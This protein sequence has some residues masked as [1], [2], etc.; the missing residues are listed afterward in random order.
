MVVSGPSRDNV[1]CAKAFYVEEDAAIAERIVEDLGRVNIRFYEEGGE[2]MA[3]GVYTTLLAFVSEA[4]ANDPRLREEVEAANA[5]GKGVVAVFLGGTVPANLGNLLDR[6]EEFVYRPGGEE[7]LVRRLTT[8]HGLRACRKETLE[9]Y[10]GPLD[11]IFVSYAHKN[12]ADVLPVIRDLQDEGFRV[13][14]DAGIEVG[15][16]WDAYIMDHLKGAKAFICFQSPEFRA[17]IYCKQEIDCALQNLPGAVVVAC[18]NPNES[19]EEIP[20]ELRELQGVLRFDHDTDRDFF[21]KLISAGELEPCRDEYR[22]SEDGKVL[23]KYLGGSAVVRIPND[24]EEVGPRAVVTPNARRV[25]VPDG[26]TKIA[27]QAFIGCGLLEE[28]DL[29]DSV[30]EIGKEA[31][32]GCGSLREIA[33]PP[34]VTIISESCFAGCVSLQ[35]VSF[36]GE[37]VEDIMQRAFE[38]CTSLIE[39]KWPN[40]IKRLWQF[41]FANCSSLDLIVPASVD[42]IEGENVYNGCQS[43]SIDPAN[44]TYS[45]K[46]N[47][48]LSR[49][50]TTLYALFLCNKAT[51]FSI[52]DGVVSISSEPTPTPIGGFGRKMGVFSNRSCLVSIHFPESLRDIGAEA[53]AGCTSLSSV[54]FPKKLEHLGLGAFHGCTSLSSV[55]FPDSL[56]EIGSQAF[57]YC[58]ALTSI[59]LPDNLESLGYEAFGWC[60]S[61]QSVR[62]PDNLAS[63]GRR[64]GSRAFAGCTSLSAV[65]LPKKLKQLG[66]E[67]FR[68]CTSLSSID[69]PSG[70]GSIGRMAFYRCTSLATIHLP[71]SV[72]SLGEG[73]F[74]SCTSLSSVRLSNRLKTLEQGVFLGCSSL[75]SMSLPDNL[76][77]V[78]SWAFLNCRELEVFVPKSVINIGANAFFGCKSLT[79][80]SDSM[81]TYSDQWGLLTSDRK[82]FVSLPI[83]FSGKTFA[84]P[85]GVERLSDQALVAVKKN[86][87]ETLIL[88]L[89]FIDSISLEKGGCDSKTVIQHPEFTCVGVEEAQ[90]HLDELQGA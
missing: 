16:E 73:A 64:S 24:V 1:S 26:V 63:I 83:G 90:K 12:S 31:F 46:E 20:E 2:S 36:L 25:I 19:V 88:P 10:E 58:E 4:A 49:D 45:F 6:S 61:L 37:K 48:L 81:F 80:D 66:S 21:E 53:F 39:I 34:E 29:P 5:N 79:L 13:W 74:R 56:A 52:P 70:L 15:S 89:S 3:P 55:H 44:E 30:V 47:C 68:D 41:A 28:I 51:S 87:I 69:L 35:R 9:P 59:L 42:A 14:Y 43:L 18:V 17:S 84:L 75:S 71:N 32:L 62:F 40:S 7:A 67:A 33:I 82:M 54:R 78:E 22:L 85:Q 50:G 8:S 23:V 11:Y 60:T 38:D 86:L 72:E 65:H 27:E 76:E 57:K 77:I